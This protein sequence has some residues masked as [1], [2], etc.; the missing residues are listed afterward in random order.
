MK[1]TSASGGSR[2]LRSTDRHKSS[3]VTILSPPV[4]DGSRLHI[5]YVHDSTHTPV[6]ALPTATAAIQDAFPDNYQ[7]DADGVLERVDL[8]PVN[9]DYEKRT[10]W[11]TTFSLSRPFGNEPYKAH[12]KGRPGNTTQGRYYVVLTQVWRLND[13]VRLR[14]G[15]PA[16]DL[17]NG[18]TIGGLG[19]KPRHEVELQAGAYR[20]GI[21]IRLDGK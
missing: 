11:N 12:H 7:R 8:R 19:G 15:L 21:G 6:L 5:N 13:T 9:A 20:N 2:T 3:L 10:E 4:Q 18:G 14:S 1:V 16:I 17:L